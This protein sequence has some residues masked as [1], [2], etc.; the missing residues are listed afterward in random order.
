MLKVRSVSAA[1]IVGAIA[2]LANQAGADST[3]KTFHGHVED[4]VVTDGSCTSPVQICT[5]GR[6]SGGLNGDLEFTMT[7][8][9][10]TNPAGTLF[11]TAQSTIHTR[12]GDVSCTDSGSF[13]TAPGSD[14]EGVHLCEITGGT[15]EFAGATGY[16]Q[17]EFRFQGT[18]GLGEYS[19]TIVTRP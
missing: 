6:L 17:E 10:P 15:G 4:E 14:G 5:V 2:F 3:Q 13:N 12:D 11:F 1:L 19:A 18:T 16:L 8:L 7:S 9:T